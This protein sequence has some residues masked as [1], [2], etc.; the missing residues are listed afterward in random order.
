MPTFTRSAMNPNG[1]YVSD[2]MD[3]SDEANFNLSNQRNQQNMMAQLALAQLRSGDARFAAERSD[4]MGMAGMNA[5]SSI[6]GQNIGHQDRMA[7]LQASANRDKAEI[8]YRTS[9]DT[10]LDNRYQD[11]FK[12]GKAGREF[13]DTMYQNQGLLAGAQAKALG[14][15]SARKE[16]A[17]KALDGTP[18]TNSASPM[19]GALNPE[20]ENQFRRDAATMDLPQAQTERAKAYANAR[21]MATSHP[22]YLAKVAQLRRMVTSK[23]DN[24]QMG[25]WGSNYLK[26]RVTGLNPDDLT[27]IDN[28]IDQASSFLV[29]RGM[30]PDA[31]REQVMQSLQG[32]D[33]KFIAP[34][35][36]GVFGTNESVISLKRHLGLPIGD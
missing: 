16:A 21:D 19:G 27:G 26:T 20:I 18:Q 15:E 17:M 35:G 31:A 8:G 33:G 7:E 12:A 36:S 22:D 4:N 5:L 11:E 25:D 23:T 30:K 3:A 32:R 10:M 29:Q 1:S 24:T 34:V 9:H 6:N 14:I 28:A 2:G 13:Q